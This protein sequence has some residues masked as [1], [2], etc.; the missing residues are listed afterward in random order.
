M[1]S[2][3]KKSKQQPKPILKPAH[4]PVDERPTRQA[5]KIPQQADKKSLIA[6]AAER[7]TA[8]GW[9]VLLVDSVSTA[10][11]ILAVRQSR[12]GPGLRYHFIQVRDIDSKYEARYNG[13]Q[14]STFVQNAFSNQA[15]PV[16]AWVYLPAAEGELP[17]FKFE[18]ADRGSRVT[19]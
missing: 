7:Y 8:A 9:Q 1:Q 16:Y 13:I 12:T 17:K 3:P 4:V 10:A 15:L 19:V 14:R 11:D 2:L 5:A 18:T 6:A